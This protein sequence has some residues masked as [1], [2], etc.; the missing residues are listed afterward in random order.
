MKGYKFFRWLLR[1]S[2]LTTV[3]F[4]MQACYGSPYSPPE[5]PDENVSVENDT[6]VSANLQL[7]E[8]DSPAGNGE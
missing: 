8:V 7:D 4:I 5:M 6:L 2:A 3:M 1:A